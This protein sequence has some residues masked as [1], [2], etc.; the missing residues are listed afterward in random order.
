MA[1]N[2]PDS[3]SV[4]DEYTAGGRTWVWSGT[5]WNS[6]D[7]TGAELSLSDFLLMGA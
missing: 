1:I 4:N 5:A 3:P 7:E 6:M 2:F